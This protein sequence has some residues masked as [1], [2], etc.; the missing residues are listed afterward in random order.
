MLRDLYM[1][2]SHCHSGYVLG[3]NPCFIAKFWYKKNG[4]RL[5][6]TPE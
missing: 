1:K 2:A 4:F 6:S 5:K 3:R